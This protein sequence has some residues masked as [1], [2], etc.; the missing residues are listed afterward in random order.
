[1]ARENKNLDI[2]T[3]VFE[4]EILFRGD[5]YDPLYIIT[6][7]DKYEVAFRKRAVKN[8]NHMSA[9]VRNIL[10][11]NEV[12]LRDHNIEDWGFDTTRLHYEIWHPRHK[13]SE[14]DDALC[15]QKEITAMRALYYACL[16]WGNNADPE[17]GKL[18][19]LLYLATQYYLSRKSNVE[20]DWACVSP[21]IMDLP[22]VAERRD[23]QIERYMSG[24]SGLEPLY[25]VYTGFCQQYEEVLRPHQYRFNGKFNA[26]VHTSRTGE[27]TEQ[28]Q[29]MSCQLYFW[30]DAKFSPELRELFWDYC[31]SLPPS[32]VQ[33]VLLQDTSALVRLILGA[34][35]KQLEIALKQST[36]TIST[37]DASVRWQADTWETAEYLCL[38][39]DL[40]SRKQ[41][42][43]C[44]ICD[45]LFEVSAK[46]RTKRYCDM[47]DANQIQY[48]NR[49]KN[50]RIKKKKT[51]NK[52]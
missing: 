18:F 51:K 17:I 3:V 8:P 34:L 19:Q 50:N 33:I 42:R 26:N 36:P 37:N 25:A 49:I 31:R 4:T 6:E 5:K 40:V 45:A 29:N 28:T 7:K 35:D 14:L 43:I 48:F 10:Y 52:S 46:Y 38:Y 20:S 1:M 32:D 13:K 30:Q 22:I 23:Y 41:Y 47:H 9:R 39:R 16:D 27:L 11:S 2:S 21:R 15:V 24:I 44:P 12:V